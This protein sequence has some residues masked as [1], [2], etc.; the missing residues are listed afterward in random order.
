MEI[1]QNMKA[2]MFCIFFITFTMISQAIFFGESEVNYLM[3]EPPQKDSQYIP[4]VSEVA[5]FF[6]WIWTGLNLIWNML[7]FNIPEL[8]L[9]IR[10]LFTIPL[11]SALLYILLPLLIKLAEAIGNLIPFT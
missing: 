4:I 3:S 8:P 1:Q 5:N 2:Y 11:W 7:T 6:G 10:L 9:S